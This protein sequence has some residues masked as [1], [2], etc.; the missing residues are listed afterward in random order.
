MPVILAPR[1]LKQEDLEIE[2]SELLHSKRQVN[3]NKSVN[4]PR[5][6]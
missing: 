2:V 5:A 4:I 1:R 6:L 3:K